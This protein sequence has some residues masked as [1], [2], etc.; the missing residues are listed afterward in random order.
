MNTAVELQ[1]KIMTSPNLS[2]GEEISPFGGL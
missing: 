1:N 2:E